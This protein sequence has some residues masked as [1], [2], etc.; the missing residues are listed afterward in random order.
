M[1]NVCLW[2]S[3]LSTNSFAAS[4]KF[5]LSRIFWRTCI[6]I[7]ACSRLFPIVD[8]R[9]VFTRFKAQKM[10][11]LSAFVACESKSNLIIFPASIIKKLLF[12]D[13]SLKFLI[14]VLVAIVSLSLYS[15]E[16]DNDCYCYTNLLMLISS[17]LISN[18]NVLSYNRLLLIITFDVVSS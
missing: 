4:A 1:P 7:R 16:L 8:L 11:S 17:L 15:N 13:T 14:M 3:F 10:P 6:K 9:Y 18:K 12:H 2:L 5:M